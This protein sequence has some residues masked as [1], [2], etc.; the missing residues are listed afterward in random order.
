MKVSSVEHYT[1]DC[2]YLAYP[3]FLTKSYRIFGGFSHL[4][5]VQLFSVDATILLKIFLIFFKLA[6]RLRPS[7]A[8]KNRD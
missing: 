3:K 4:H 7:E 2:E 6:V 1:I 8:S 5:F